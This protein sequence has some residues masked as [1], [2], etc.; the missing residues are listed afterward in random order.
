MSAMGQMRPSRHVCV[1]SGLP[2]DS[3]RAAHRTECRLR[4]RR[5]HRFDL[6]SVRCLLVLQRIG[7]LFQRRGL[8]MAFFFG[9]GLTSPT[10]A[11]LPGIACALSCCLRL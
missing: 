3:G 9:A 10:L 4:A 2:L 5:R 11:D 1:T 8:L 6:G 7:K